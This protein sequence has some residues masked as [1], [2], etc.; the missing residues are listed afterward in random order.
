M[1]VNDE[2]KSILRRLQ[3]AS[4][5]YDRKKWE[6]ENLNKN[7]LKD[8][9][10]RN[11]G[12][13]VSHNFAARYCRHPYFVY[14]PNLMQGFQNIEQFGSTRSQRTLSAHPAQRGSYQ[15][16]EVGTPGSVLQEE[17]EEQFRPLTAPKQ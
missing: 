16:G 12:T 17:G 8:N 2:N 9:I 13:L 14:T 11:S 6:D 4:S 3:G 7:Y 1:R 15:P 5:V 10:L